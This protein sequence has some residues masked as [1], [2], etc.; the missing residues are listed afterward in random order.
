[1]SDADTNI[2]GGGFSPAYNFSH[3]RGGSQIYD[4]SDDEKS[5]QKVA[6]RGPVS[7]EYPPRDDARPGAVGASMSNA[8]TSPTVTNWRPSCT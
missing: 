5:I 4:A 8:S 3:H 2:G 6:Q 7:S 1:M